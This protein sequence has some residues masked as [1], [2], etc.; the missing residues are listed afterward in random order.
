MTSTESIRGIKRKEVERVAFRGYLGTNQANITGNAFNIVNID[1]V[2]HDLGKNFDTT[3]HRF[4]VPVSGLYAIFGQIY[5]N[6]VI[7]DSRYLASVFKNGTDSIHEMGAQASL[8]GGLS[9]PIY[10]EYFLEKDEYLDLR[11]FPF[12]GGGVNTVDVLGG[13]NFYH[14]TFFGVRLITKEGTRQ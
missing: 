6:D 9:A 3:L 1:T 7:T 4:V 10:D 13:A 5:F 14:V 11:A 2:V 12:V 8:A